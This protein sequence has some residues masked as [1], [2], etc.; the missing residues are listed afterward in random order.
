[1]GL[2]LTVALAIVACVSGVIAS[3]F[4]VSRMLAMLVKMKLVPYKDVGIPGRRQ[5]TT[6][7]Y[8][9]VFAALLALFFDLSRIAALG[10]LFYLVMDAA[11]H[12]G[13]LTKLRSKLGANALVVVIALVCDIALF[14]GLT[15]SKAG[16]DPTVLAFA[17]IGFVVIFGGEWLYLRKRD[18]DDGTAA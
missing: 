17:G 10:A 3:V 12:W 9:I 16:S 18:A 4:A 15:A 14:A 7:T 8:T 11:I 5:Y 1:M 6:L 13:V 2:Y